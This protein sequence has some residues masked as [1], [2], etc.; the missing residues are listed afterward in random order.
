M[1]WLRSTGSTVISQLFDTFIVL[2]IAFWLTGK[3]STEVY[4]TS[5]LAGYFVKLVIAIAMTPLI[6]AGHAVIEKQLKKD[7]NDN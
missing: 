7:H 6:Y 5:A 2:G 4:I 3:M 1:I